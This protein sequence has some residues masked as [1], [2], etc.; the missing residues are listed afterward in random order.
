[1]AAISNNIFAGSMAP[2]DVT[3]YML[4][5]GVPDYSDMIQYNN[6]ETGY[7]FLIV[8][9]IPIFMDKLRTLSDEYDML[10]KN[11][12]HI[13]E[14]DFRGI[15]G[16]ED[17]TSDP[18][19]VNNGYGT[20]INM[21][22]NVSAQSASTFSMRFYERG[23]MTISKTHELFLRGLKDPKSKVKTYNGLLRGPDG[24]R[25]GAIMQESGFEYETFKFLYFVTNNTALQIERAALI[26]GAQP[27]NAAYGELT[28]SDRGTIGF[29]EITAS[30]SGVP[31]FGPMINA[32]AQEFLD[33]INK[34]TVFEE[35][36]FGY[37]ALQSM[38]P[39]DTHGWTYSPRITDV[40][41]STVSIS[42]G[43]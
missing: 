25:N 27:T 38:D 5:R 23:G 7:S 4:M 12:R 8:L 20:N 10:I 17:I 9:E 22:T 39:A 28:N 3:K 43:P 13:L 18:S 37:R 41:G 31:L 42:T 40:T 19:E 21:I 36:K 16:F 30:F 15:D 35:V 14:Y 32:K 29:S 6:F 11:Y 33:W 24:T 2:R 1:M 26:V 34:S